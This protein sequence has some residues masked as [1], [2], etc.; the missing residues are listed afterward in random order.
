MEDTGNG[1]SNSKQLSIYNLFKGDKDLFQVNFVSQGLHVCKMLMD[2][3]KGKMKVQSLY[4]K[5]SRIGFS[6]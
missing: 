3:M 6:L 5:G 4:Q 1:L 2:Q